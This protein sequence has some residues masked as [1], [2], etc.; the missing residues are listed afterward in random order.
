MCK[1]EIMGLTLEE[2]QKELAGLG[3]KKFR[4]EQVFRWLYEKAATDFSQ[5]SNL[6]KEARQQL[7]ERYTIATSQVKVLKEYKSRDGL[8]HKVLLELTDGATVET[9]L[10]HHDYGYSV[11]LSSQVGCAMNC[12]FCASGLH[13]F[14]RNLT[15]AEILAQLYFFQSGLQP[16]GERVSRIVVMGSGEPML[17][18][19]HVLK[20]L[21]ILHSDRGQC[22]GWRNMTVSTCGVV[23]G[24]EEL[25]A[26]GR[27]INLAISLTGLPWNCGTG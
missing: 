6:S 22:I 11:C 13:G 10:M 17:N 5:M 8:T 19:D 12:A 3:M 21:D 9:V 24:I 20:A 14:V 2:L 4:A 23:P 26:Q 1:K 25:T 15:A 27:N 18:L 7:E 16:R